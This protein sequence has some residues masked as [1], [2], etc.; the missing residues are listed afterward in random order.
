MLF[1][2]DKISLSLTLTRLAYACAYKQKNKAFNV[3]I[4][5]Q[6]VLILNALC[7]VNNFCMT[8]TGDL[9]YIYAMC[10]TDFQTPY[11]FMDT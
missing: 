10:R 7:F 5:T 2:T 6:T 3:N 9:L 8:A 11:F 1:I 4:S